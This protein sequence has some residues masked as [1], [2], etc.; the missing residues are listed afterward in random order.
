MLNSRQIF[1]FNIL[2]INIDSFLVI[3]NMWSRET[4]SKHKMHYFTNFYIEARGHL[5]LH[6]IINK[7]GSFTSFCSTNVWNKIRY[8]G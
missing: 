4:I 8:A 5:L 3:S 6:L 7:S 1:S 2:N